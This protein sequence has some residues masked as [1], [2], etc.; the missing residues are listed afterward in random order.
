MYAINTQ[1][2]STLLD[3][4]LT[5]AYLQLV[6]DQPGGLGVI[7]LPPCHRRPG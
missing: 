1:E 3:V 5:G 7:G 2:I 6:E 4:P